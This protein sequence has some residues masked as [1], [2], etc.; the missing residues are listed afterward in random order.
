[1][2]GEQCARDKVSR[3]KEWKEEELTVGRHKKMV[4]ELQA[5]CAVTE[6][7]E[8]RGSRRKM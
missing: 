6:A 8:E 4:R 5:E 2:L 7:K 3:R 1:M